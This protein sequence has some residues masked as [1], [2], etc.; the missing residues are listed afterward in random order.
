[1]RRTKI[2]HN[3]TL[4]HLAKAFDI[5]EISEKEIQNHPLWAYEEA[6]VSNRAF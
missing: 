6:V 5:L 4:C 1:M 2:V 3:F